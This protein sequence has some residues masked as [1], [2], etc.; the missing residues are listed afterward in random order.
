MLQDAFFGLKYIHYWTDSPSSQYRNRYIFNH[1]YNHFSVYGIFADWNYFEVGHGKG[2]CD[3][4]GGTCKRAASEAVKQG[5]VSIQD[6]RDVFNWATKN[7]KAIS[8]MFYSDEEY[9]SAANCSNST[10]F[11]SIFFNISAKSFTVTVLFMVSG[12]GET[13]TARDLRLFSFRLIF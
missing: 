7:E 10:F 13:S 5:K 2:P 3:G 11:V 1:I 9:N 8:Y 6:A 4:I 12:L